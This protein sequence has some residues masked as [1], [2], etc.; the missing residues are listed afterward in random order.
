VRDADLSDT[1]HFVRAKQFEPINLHSL[2]QGL[3]IDDINWLALDAAT[4]V[5]SQET[6]KRRSL[7]LQLIAWIF[8]DYLI[9]LLKVI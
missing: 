7:G 2:T 8:N 9:P 6:Q 5:S 1:R 3:R 4:R